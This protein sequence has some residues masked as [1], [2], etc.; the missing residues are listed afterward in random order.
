MQNLK[1]NLTILS[2]EILNEKIN[3]QKRLF[4]LIKLF[5]LHN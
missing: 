5:E 4:F 1:D 2:N 3:L